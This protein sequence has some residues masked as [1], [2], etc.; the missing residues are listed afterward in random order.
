MRATILSMCALLALAAGPACATDAGFKDWWA[1]CD[2][3]RQCTAFGYSE[4]A[5]E[6]RAFLKLTRGAGAADAP[7]IEIMTDLEA[8]IWTV[9]VDGKP[10]AGLAGLKREDDRVRLTPAQSATVVAAIAN[11]ANLDVLA[12]GQTAMV[13][14]AGSS[15]T[16]RWLDDQQKRAGTVTALV[17]KGVKPAAAVPPPPALP[18]VK[19]AAAV[20]QKDLPTKLPKPVQ[21]LLTEC[22]AGIGERLETEPVIARLS[23]GVILYAPLCYA[24]AYNLVHTFIVADEQGKGARPLTIQYQNGSATSELMNI[25]FDPQRQALSNFEKGRGVGDCGG[26]NAW[27]WTGKAFEVVEEMRM[28]ECRG[29]GAEDW[30]I[31]FRARDR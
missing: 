27:V 15:A 1:A 8:A 19:A 24:G 17:A 7:A 16:L 3:A 28:G 29:V 9:R 11:G 26:V 13:S 25:N 21:A 5:S 30:P 18:L 23:P 20:S 12:G 31:T 22:E 4:E 2:N 10:V 14:L 6:S